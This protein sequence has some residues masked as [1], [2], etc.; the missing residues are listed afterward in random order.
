MGNPGV[1]G[2]AHKK[3]RKDALAA[4][5]DGQRCW[6][7]RKPMHIWQALDLDHTRPVALGGANSLRVLTH[8]RCL[9]TVP[10]AQG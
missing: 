9:A 2:Y 5:R 7:C 8:A 1:Y 6:R 3:A 10:L 4:F